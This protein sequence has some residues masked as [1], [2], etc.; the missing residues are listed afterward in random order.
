[1]KIDYEY[2]GVDIEIEFDYYPY[3]PATYEYPSE[4]GYTNIIDVFHKGESIFELVSSN[5]LEH[6]EAEIY[7]DIWEGE[8]ERS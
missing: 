5:I 8:S 1:M 3:V 6:L 2:E 7:K 4:G